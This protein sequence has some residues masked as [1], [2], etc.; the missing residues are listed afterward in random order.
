[1]SDGPL[2]TS[3]KG[4]SAIVTGA[5]GGIGRAIAT[6]LV[7]AGADVLITYR[8]SQQAA[9]AAVEEL[10]A[11]GPG[12]CRA[13]SVDVRQSEDLTR[14]IAEATEAFDRLDILVNNAGV[15][16]DT[17][18]M[19]MSEEAWDTVVE[20]N[21]R[22]TFLASKAAL[23][24]MIRARWGRII[25]ITS[26]VGRLGNP[27][28]ANYAAAKAGIIGFTRSL[29]LEVA[30]RGITVNAIAPGFVATDMTAGL[31]DEQREFLLGRIPMGRIAAPNE[32]A[33]LAAFLASDAA[34]YITGQTFNVDGGV[35]MS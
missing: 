19:R 30:S 17:L 3:L 20:T 32:I 13:T 11:L 2:S 9:E 21:L 16:D 15:T 18:V 8:S 12:T 29:A 23:R 5:G 25:N 1:M 10:N 4:R 7:A 24:G 14:L 33:P 27:G 35:V 6:E 22:G 26:V 34:A 31:N 28:Q